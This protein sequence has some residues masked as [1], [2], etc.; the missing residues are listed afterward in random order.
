MKYYTPTN[1]EAM[2]TLSFCPLD[3]QVLGY[4]AHYAQPYTPSQLKAEKGSGEPFIQPDLVLLWAG[5]RQAGGSIGRCD[6]G[7]GFKAATPP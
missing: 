2:S 3:R 4:R 7:L 5:V 1:T 6:K